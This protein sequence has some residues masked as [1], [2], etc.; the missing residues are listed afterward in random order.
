[1]NARIATP[2]AAVLLVA[3]CSSSSEPEAALTATQEA[4]AT[5]A[6]AD[7]TPAEQE[8]VEA[9]ETAPDELAAAII[10]GEEE[11][12]GLA[13][14]AS[15]A[16]LSP[17]FEQV[18][19]IAVEFSATGVDN[20]VGVW[21]SNSLE[22]GGGIIMA[23]DGMAQEFTVWPDADSTD[24]AISPADPSVESAKACLE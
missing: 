15:A 20:Q 5:E 19:F 1:M 12:A 3:A 2:I 7:P 23:V 8:P 11:G 21:A 9:C 10:D 16:V 17:D 24:A 13:P 14:V 18:Y 6:A 4:P 22:P